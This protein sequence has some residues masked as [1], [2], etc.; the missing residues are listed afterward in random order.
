MAEQLALRYS[1]AWRASDAWPRVLE[2][3]RRVVSVI[4]LKEAAHDLDTQPSYLAN[5][6]AERDRHYL[7]AEWLLYFVVKDPTTKLLGTIAD[8]ATCDVKRREPLTAVERLSR[9]ESAVS[10]LGP[11]IEALVRRKAGL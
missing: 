5:A 2:E 7:R 4:T 9:L 11:E 10:D 8:L 3:I 1:P 6:L